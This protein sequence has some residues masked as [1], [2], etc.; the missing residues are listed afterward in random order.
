MEDYNRYYRIVATPYLWD[1]D[2]SILWINSPER[3]RFSM[4]GEWAIVT[5]KELPDNPDFPYYTNDEII[6]FIYDNWGE[7]NPIDST[8]KP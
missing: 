8:Q 3:A 1:L 2:Y 7:W 4:T 5:Y 6:Q